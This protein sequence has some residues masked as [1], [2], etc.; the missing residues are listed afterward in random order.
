MRL[1]VKKPSI[2]MLDVCEESSE[3]VKQPPCKLH[4]YC[5]NFKLE[6]FAK[7]LCMQKKTHMRAPALTSV[8]FFTRV[9]M[10]LPYRRL[11]FLGMA[12]TASSF[13]SSACL[14]AILP[15]SAAFSSLPG[16]TRASP[17]PLCS[18]KDK[19]INRGCLKKVHAQTIKPIWHA[20]ARAAEKKSHCE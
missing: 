10:I 5:S 7:K 2:L 14:R 20:L 6:K 17:A 15:G 16:R 11:F 3:N 8:D 4:R 18:C 9:C 12:M 13:S 19:A 1:L